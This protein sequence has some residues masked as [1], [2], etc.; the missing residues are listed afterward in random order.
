MSDSAGRAELEQLRAELEVLRQQV[1]Q[2]RAR[3][4]QAT[5]LAVDHTSSTVELELVRPDGGTETVGGVPW[6]PSFLPQ[7]GSLVPVTLD[8]VQ[9]VPVPQ[10]LDPNGL[11]SVDQVIAQQVIAG[12]VD[13]AAAIEALPRGFVAGAARGSIDPASTTA[14]LGLMEFTFETQP[15]R[16]YK[17]CSTPIYTKADTAT[18]RVDVQFRYEM[19]LDPEVEP[20]AVD[21]TSPR[22]H[23]VMDQEVPTA[24]GRPAMFSRLIG[25]YNDYRHWRLLLCI[26]TFGGSSVQFGI[27]GAGSLETNGWEFEPIQVWVE[28]MGRH[29]WTNRWKDNNGG[30]TTTDGTPTP[31]P[32]PPSVVRRTQD[33]LAEWTRTWLGNGTARDAA[34][35]GVEALQGQSP[36]YPAGGNYRSMIG[37]PSAMIADVAGSTIEKVEVYLYANHWHPD[38]GGILVMGTHGNTFA[39]A[40]F[41][42]TAVIPDRTRHPGWPKPGGLWVD[43][44]YMG[45]GLLDG[46]IRGLTLGP[47]PDTNSV[48][49]GRI[50]GAGMTNPPTFRVTFTK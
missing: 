33:Y 30:G 5:V 22:F 6:P 29:P 27:N 32:P 49:Y 17:L 24:A 28:D 35:T 23:R 4:Q 38:S 14:E 12:G 8:G 37:F 3:Q 44:S 31:T 13:L 11:A 15:G 9:P 19:S 18:N 7:V 34:V 20:P 41:G 26:R 45:A 1:R 10:R 36:Y 47:A 25:P 46:T 21:I 48:Y 50:N 40:T 16:V 2:A 39:P 43:V 42:G